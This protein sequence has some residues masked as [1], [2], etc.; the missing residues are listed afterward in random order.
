[1]TDE[2]IIYEKSFIKRNSF[3]IGC[4]FIVLIYAIALENMESLKTLSAIDYGIFAISIGFIITVA[5]FLMYINNRGIKKLISAIIGIYFLFQTIMVVFDI[6]SLSHSLYFL[7]LSL[8]C[9]LNALLE[10]KE[11]IK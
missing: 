4:C 7:F 3:W 5:C 11:V 9:F 6:I 1:M 2:P 10:N 8:A